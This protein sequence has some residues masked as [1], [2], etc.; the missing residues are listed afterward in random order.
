M[1]MDMVRPLHKTCQGAATEKQEQQDH[2]PSQR[3][4]APQR[5]RGMLAPRKT[6][7]ARLRILSDVC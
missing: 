7:P 5:G 2:I 3:I 6:G 1:V 4:T